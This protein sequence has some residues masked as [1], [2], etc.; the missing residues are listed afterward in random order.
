MVL[1]KTKFQLNNCFRYLF[2]A[3][4]CFFFEFSN[5]ES[6]K[7]SQ[8]INVLVWDEQQP[9]QKEAYDNFLG[10]AIAEHLG[11]NPALNVRSAK[12]DDPQQGISSKSLDWSD[13]I[14]WWGHVRHDEISSKKSK[15]IVKLIKKGE[16]SLIVLHSAHWSSPFI[17][18][19]N[20]RT[21]MD[22]QKT[23]GKSKSS[24]FPLTTPSKF[25]KPFI[26]ALEIFVIIPS[27]GL[28]ISH[29]NPISPTALAPI[30]IIAI[31]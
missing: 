23:Y 13:V 2:L 16:L 3:F 17:E 12:L 7:K 22:F 10:N 4:F 9:K 24:D 31:S 21:K 30:S 5:A 28:A 18:A 27:V 1:Y 29:N 8:K 6:L 26:C 20:E 15:E 11:K 14:V 25:L 19:M